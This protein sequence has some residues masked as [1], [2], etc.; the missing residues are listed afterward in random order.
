MGGAGGRLGCPTARESAT[1][2]SPQGTKSRE[3]TFSGGA[4]LWHGSGP[5][6]G[7]T[8][9]V[10]GCIYRLFFQYGGPSGWLGLPTSDPVNTPDGQRQTFEGGVVVYQRTPDACEATRQAPAPSAGVAAATAGGGQPPKAALDL[11]FD[12]SRGD[13]LVV[14]SAV[15]ASRAQAANYQRLRTQA[16]VFTDRAAGTTPLKL[17]WNEARGAHVAVATVDGERD[18]LAAGDEFEG[19][20]GFVYTD[21]KPGTAPLKQFSNAASRHYRLTAT[22][23]DEAQATAEGYSFVRIEGYAPTAP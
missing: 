21:P 14:A 16:Y 18:A 8:F 7:Q 23:E 22:A 10:S 15:S 20:Q 5:R 12:S 13:Y 19:I 1:A 4:I 2:D 11:F 3:M 9:A 6:A 17:Y